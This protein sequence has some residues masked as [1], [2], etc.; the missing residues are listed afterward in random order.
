MTEAATMISTL[1]YPPPVNPKKMM[2]D[3]ITDQF[4]VKWATEDRMGGNFVGGGENGSSLS[5]VLS[6]A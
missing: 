1:S 2:E 5:C 4:D 3:G 6:V